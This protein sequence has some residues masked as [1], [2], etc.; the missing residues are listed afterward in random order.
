MKR[1]FLKCIAGAGLLTFAALT[2]AAQSGAK[3][4]EWT[5]YGGDLGNTRYSPLDQISADNFSKLQV[6]WRFKTESLGP[7]TEYNLEATPLM[8]KGVVYSVAGTRRAVVA[9]DGA[10]GELLWV[11]GEREGARGAAAPRQLSGRGLSY[12]TDGREERIYYVTPGYRLVALDAKTGALVPSFGTNGV[13]DLKLNDDQEIDLVTGEVGLHSA[14]IVA[15]DTIIVGAAHKS[16]G[17]PKSRGNVKGFVRG[18][19]VR[20][21]KRL[22]IFHTIPKPGEFG[23]DTWEKDSADY[24]GNTGVWGQISVDPDLGMAYLP[25]ELP[26]GDY[27]GGHRPGNGLFGESVVAVD[28]KTGQRKWHYQLVHHGI[29]D[30]DIPCAPM[31]V[32]INV[33]GRAIK[34]LAQPTKQA[35][36]YV[37]DRTNG[38]PV[39]PIVERPVEQST[40]P[41]EKTSPTQPFPTKPPAYNK[42][43]AVID[44]LIDFTPELHAEAV[45]LAS[46]YHMGP[47]FTPPVVSKPEG[48]LGT[49]AMATANGGTVWQGGSY[50]PETHIAYMYSRR[51]IGSLGLLPPP[52]PSVSDMNYVQGSAQTGVRSAGGAG[53]DG[54]AAPGGPAETNV[55][56]LAVQGLPLAK[57]PY[58]QIT[59]IDLNKGEILWEVAHGETPDDIRNNPALKG[60]NIPRTGRAGIIGTLITK[61]LVIAGEAGTFT[62]PSGQKGAMMRAYDKTNG[63]EV[64]A[65]YMPAGQTGSP[66]TYML[67]GKQYIV[68]A[69]GGPGY[70]AEFIAYR[71]PN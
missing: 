14:P 45:K 1:T 12:W 70:P 26:T 48:P 9:L 39:W 30:M 33:N 51:V 16:G 43:G 27:Y 49:L 7:R 34:A 20:T 36:L 56:V 24:T 47:V 37:F 67:N 66:M 63:K 42:Q 52:S 58:G 60:L 13:L 3:N 38:Q 8:A 31:L 64:G 59:A 11:H 54:G 17:V 44:D 29:W 32:D 18:F 4:G 50:D 69:V 25:V 23:Y 71:L 65:V 61:N 41:G 46:M 10:T 40:V 55:R 68:V 35:F 21:G 53:A 57:P 5:T 6:A 28:L 15:G 19:D 22:W 2:A 62:T